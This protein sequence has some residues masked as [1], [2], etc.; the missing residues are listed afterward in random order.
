[1]DLILALDRA[2]MT[3]LVLHLRAQHVEAAVVPSLQP[4]RQGDEATHSNQAAILNQLTWRR[5]P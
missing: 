4:S 2:L 3:L 5:V 1:M